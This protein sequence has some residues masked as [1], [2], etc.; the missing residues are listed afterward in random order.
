L[1]M[2]LRGNAIPEGLAAS[3]THH[4]EAHYRQHRNQAQSG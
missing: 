1:V 4:D 3:D 2:R